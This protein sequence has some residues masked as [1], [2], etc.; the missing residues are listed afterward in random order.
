VY[1]P[2]NIVDA[3]DYKLDTV[4][5]IVDEESKEITTDEYNLLLRVCMSEAG[6]QYGEPMEG[7]IAV[8]ETILN[9][10][11]MGMGSIEDVIESAYSTADNGEP[12]DTVVEA[13]DTAL[14]SRMYP[15]NMIYFRTEHYHT[16]FGTPYMKIGNHYFSLEEN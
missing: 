3:T 2:T 16:E 1:Q 8:V 13:V 7:K 4:N 6:G 14:S 9:R 11:D 10:V 15:T 12:D 5:D